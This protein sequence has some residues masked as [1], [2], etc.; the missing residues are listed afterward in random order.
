M[1]NSFATFGE[2][3]CYI[4]MKRIVNMEEVIQVSAVPVN[5]IWCAFKLA[6]MSPFFP[7]FNISEARHGQ[8]PVT[9]LSTEKGKFGKKGRIDPNKLE[10]SGLIEVEIPSTYRIKL[11]L[12]DDTVETV[13]TNDAEAGYLLR[14][15]S[16]VENIEKFHSMAIKG[17][18][19]KALEELMIDDKVDE[20]P[21]GKRPVGF[22][23]HRCQ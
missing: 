4:S 19:A 5:G 23:N 17:Q 9:I 1:E 20:L 21:T 16:S 14:L 13:Y 6:P 12:E 10:S 2:Q 7:M 3:F 18:W 11:K 8:N 15:M 22:V